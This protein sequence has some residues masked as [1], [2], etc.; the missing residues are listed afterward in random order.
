MGWTSMF[1]GYKLVPAGP[2]ILQ[3]PEA[4]HYYLEGR[5]AA[6]VTSELDTRHIESADRRAMPGQ[7]H[8]KAS[9]GT[10]GVE[11]CKYQLDMGGSAQQVRL[12]MLAEESARLKDVMLSPPQPVAAL[13]Q[14]NSQ[15]VNALSVSPF[16]DTVDAQMLALDQQI[17]DIEQRTRM[18]TQEAIEKRSGDAGEY[19]CPSAHVRGTADQLM[20][21]LDQRLQDM[22]L[23]AR[24]LPVSNV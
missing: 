12:S 1:A 23:R 10:V 17:R 22:E 15:L 20:Q 21:A 4:E 11:E 24:M 19:D 16:T 14:V 6:L 3:D 9:V 18:L 2:D 13:M 7:I 5:R 8:Q